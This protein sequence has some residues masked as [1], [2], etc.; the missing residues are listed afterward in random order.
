MR[1]VLRKCEQCRATSLA[2]PAIGTGNHMFPEDVVFRIFREEFEIFSSSQDMFIMKNIR[3]VVFGKQ[4]TTQPPQAHGKQTSP[5]VINWLSSM[6]TQ[7][8]SSKPTIAEAPQST[9][10]T[11]FTPLY[12]G[13]P[14][15]VVKLQVF[16]L[17]N[18]NIDTALDEVDA[19][20]KNQTTAKEI[21]HEKVFDV[22]LEHWSKVQE[23]A[24]H[25]DVRITCQKSSVALIEGLVTNVSDCKDELVRLITEF[26][27]EERKRNQMKYISKNVQWHHLKGSQEVKYGS[28]VNGLIETAS[29]ENKQFLEI[30]RSGQQYE[31]DLIRMVEK[32]KKTGRTEKITRKS[33]VESSSGTGR[34]M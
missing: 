6:F 22:F 15:Q 2:M 27:E 13:E 12:T 25:H 29:M 8:T 5:S 16:A 11:S 10:I 4:L 23:L 17:S 9:P 18:Q 20:V 32:N 14:K 21:E 34:F 26:V 30:T 1:E 3:I 28:E 19:F 24:R 31:I 33:L 7:L